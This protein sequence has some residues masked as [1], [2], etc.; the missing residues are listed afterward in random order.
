MLLGRNT[1]HFPN[2][3][4]DAFVT[5]PNH[6]HGIVVINAGAKDLSPD[7]ANDDSPPSHEIDG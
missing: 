7:L 6:V 5:M 4:L 3:S 1:E 2:V